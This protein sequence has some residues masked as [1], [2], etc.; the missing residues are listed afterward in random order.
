MSSEMGALREFSISRPLLIYGVGGG[1]KRVRTAQPGKTFELMVNYDNLSAEERTYGIL[2]K[3]ELA[4][5]PLSGVN[6]GSCFYQIDLQIQNEL[7]VFTQSLGLPRIE[8]VIE[9]KKEEIADLEKLLNFYQEQLEFDPKQFLI[10]LPYADLSWDE[11]RLTCIREAKDL[12]F[13]CFA[14]CEDLLSED[15]K[16]TQVL[17]GVAFL[18]LQEGQWIDVVT[19]VCIKNKLDLPKKIEELSKQVDILRHSVSS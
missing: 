17:K 16:A 18:S 13:G 10:E 6:D 4:N 3:V 7:Q 5:R 9:K 2:K 19:D 12:Q 8:K 15:E 14:V 1:E 11:P